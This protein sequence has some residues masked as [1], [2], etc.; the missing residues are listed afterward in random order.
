MKSTRSSL[1]MQLSKPSA[2][3]AGL[4]AASLA[5]VGTIAVRQ[6]LASTVPNAFETESGT[7]TGGAKIT[8]SSGASGGSAVKFGASAPV[9]VGF[10]HPGVYVTPTQLDFAK[11]KLASSAQ[12]WTNTYGYMSTAKGAV[13]A[14]ATV[15]QVYG[16]ISYVPHPVASIDCTANNAGCNALISDGIAAYTD[17][18]KYYLSTTSDRAQ[19][20]QTATTI[21][22][23]WSSTATS[24]NGSQAQLEIGW[25][26]DTYARA[27]ELIRY[28]YN[29]TAGQPT[30]D[31]AGLITMMNNVFKPAIQSGASNP[32]GNWELAMASGMMSMGVFTD[33]RATFNTGLSLWRGRVP[34]YIYESTDN[35]GNGQPIAPPGGR[36]TT[37]ISLT[38]F[39]LGDGGAGA[40]SC[41]IPS[42]FGYHNGMS[43]ETCRDLSHVGLGLS[44]ISNGAETARIQGVDLFAEQKQRLADGYEFAATLT[45]THLNTGAWPNSPCGGEP[46]IYTGCTVS[47][48]NPCDGTGGS[49]YKLGWENGFN[50]LSN[51]LGMSMPNTLSMITN[52]VRPSSYKADQSTA[53]ES[54]TG[55]IN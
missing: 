6:I 23:A 42:G 31:S 12:P 24:W 1:Y 11:A 7:L 54:L 4:L 45:Q 38:C 14:P 51:H 37:Q 46:G 34:A 29:P 18:L 8:V 10:V 35:N 16:S 44:M 47:G 32:N 22:N 25:A 40:T 43:Q 27:A 13:V 41:T 53:W 49:G 48:S 17:A 52:V 19:Y 2:K 30:L 39:W 3:R 50:E 36:F 9:P 33:I 26:S 15:G 55:P 28:T 20:A 21:L 5:I